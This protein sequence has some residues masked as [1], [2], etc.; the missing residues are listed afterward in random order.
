MS[1]GGLDVSELSD[2][3][4]DLIQL[5]TTTFPQESKKFMRTEGNK[6]RKEIV[7]TAKSKGIKK[8][9]GNY[10][11]G[12]KRGKVYKYDGDEIAVRVYHKNMD[13][14]QQPHGHLIEYGHRVTDKAGNEL[15]FARGYHVY[16]DGSNKYKPTFHQNC[17]AFIDD[18]LDKGM[19]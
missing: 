2:F 11:R 18:M 19:S 1:L 4:K 13:K 12:I 5:A 15:G 16:R 17:E 7:K 3:S 6:M 10:L 14:N 9:T 8:K